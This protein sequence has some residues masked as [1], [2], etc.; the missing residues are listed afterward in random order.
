MQPPIFT[1]PLYIHRV[2]RNLLDAPATP[3]PLRQPE[4]TPG[5]AGIHEKQ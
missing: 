1:G 2:L 3:S 4:A 5:E